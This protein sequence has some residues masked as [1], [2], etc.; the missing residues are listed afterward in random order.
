MKYSV[1]SVYG[2]PPQACWNAY[3]DYKVILFDSFLS[4]QFCPVKPILRLVQLMGLF[5]EK[6]IVIFAQVCQHWKIIACKHMTWNMH[7][8]KECKDTVSGRVLSHTT[9][10]MFTLIVTQKIKVYLHQRPIYNCALL[11]CLSC[12]LCVN[13]SQKAVLI[14]TYHIN[15][16][17][18]SEQWVILETKLSYANDN[19]SGSRYKGYDIEWKVCLWALLASCSFNYQI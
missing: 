2:F 8:Q 12:Q 1:I 16:W 15:Y 11:L 17:C 3:F 19:Y 10:S 5:V 6:T 18:L 14:C 13:K 9:W 4:L 7:A